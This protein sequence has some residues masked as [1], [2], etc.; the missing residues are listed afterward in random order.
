MGSGSNDDETKDATKVSTPPTDPIDPIQGMK[1]EILRAMQAGFHA[2]NTN[3]EVVLHEVGELRDRVIVIERWKDDVGLRRVTS[4]RV[5]EL[6]RQP[7]ESDLR[8]AAELSKEVVAREALEK[9]VDRSLELLEYLAG[10]TK[11]PM[12]RRIAV[13]VGGA[14]IM[15]AA[16][17]T[18]SMQARS[19]AKAEAAESAKAKP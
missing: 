19:A 10:I 1:V 17:W 3:V 18:Q 6:V 9:K 7:S 16:G 12:V 11:R 8:N 4:E 15:W 2:V 14:L 13:V 5:R